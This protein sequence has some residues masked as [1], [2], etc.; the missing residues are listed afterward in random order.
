[1]P[2]IRKRTSRRLGLR[3]KYAVEKKVK[4]HHRKIKKNAKKLSKAG[5]RPTKAKRRDVVPNSFPDKEELIN[6]M[7]AQE[8]MEK[9]RK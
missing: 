5:V 8:L 6:Q 4:D 1:M 2:K 7:E 9:E 3:E